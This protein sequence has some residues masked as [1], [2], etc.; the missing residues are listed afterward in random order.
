MND[1]IDELAAN[2]AWLLLQESNNPIRR[3]WI[4]GYALN[5]TVEAD[6]PE[7]MLMILQKALGAAD[8]LLNTH[9]HQQW[10]RDQIELHAS[11]VELVESGL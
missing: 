1:D 8:D 9:Q 2:T 5:K 7:L 6:R 4:V 10:Y 11:V 3:G